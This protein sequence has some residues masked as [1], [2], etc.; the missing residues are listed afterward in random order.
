METKT[1]FIIR[2]TKGDAS[3]AVR[4]AVEHCKEKHIQYLK[5]E[6]GEYHFYP[7]TASEDTN[8]C[9][10]NHGHN[11]YKRTA[12]LITDMKDFTVDCSG[13]LLVFHG[14]MNAFI[15]RRCGNV[16]VRGARILF[17]RTL[18]AQFR[19][20]AA[21]GGCTELTQD[22]QQGYV[23]E[24]GLLYLEN[25]QGYR[26]LVYT[27]EE[28]TPDGAF[29]YG[30][31]CFGKDFLLLKNEDLGNGKIRIYNPPRTPA[32]GNYVV[33][34]AAERYANAVLFLESKDVFAVDC[35][36]YSS[37]GIAYHAQRC[38]N[39]T[40]ER[41][42]TEKYGSRC[43]SANADASHFVGCRG[44]VRISGCHFRHQLDD[45]V[46]VHGVFTKIIAKDEQ[47]I[48]VK[49]AHYQCRGLELF[50]RGCRIEALNRKSLIPYKASTVVRLDVLN[51]ESTRLF[52][53]DGTDGFEV[54]DLVDS[55]DFYPDVIIENCRFINN[56]ARG[57]LI[58]AKGKVI[59]KNNY[60]HVPGIA[61]DLESDSTYWYE[62]GGVRELSI[63][64]NIFDDC[65]YIE[66]RTWGSDVIFTT[67][68]EEIEPG[69]YYHGK[70]IIKN[71]DFSNC[72]VPV[73]D[74]EN[75]EWLIMENNKMNHVPDAVKLRHCGRIE[76]S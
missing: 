15:V 12:F 5:L 67:R 47:S 50:E 66:G 53:E 23:Y 71:N 38:E 31:Q 62:S 45:G 70:I 7:E 28:I 39:V 61:I 43:F 21:S 51:I 76:R 65:C 58:G 63:E 18:H 32:K 24:N 46:N 33:L 75:I 2:H 49:Y 42:R 11:G 26:N 37:F 22:G 68:R 55:I 72:R 25:E 9:V 6:K 4:E 19:V 64:N 35:C 52:L 44:L 16:T 13:S 29:V 54:G 41:C 56:R 57:I 10:S 74:A 36:V 30:E 60:F 69:K 3:I 27:C 59:I 14:A 1:E 40:L 8:C 48:I 73:I 34:V 17:E 20:T